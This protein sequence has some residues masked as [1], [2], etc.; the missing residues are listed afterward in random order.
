M[1]ELP[2]GYDAILS[3]L[4]DQIRTARL[5]A[6]LAVN[7]ELVLL[8]WRIG[9]QILKRQQEEGLGS[10]VIERLA[11]D[12]RKEFPEMKG[13]SPHNLKYMR[14]FA[15]AY[16]EELIVQQAAAQIPWFHNCVILYKVKNSVARDFYIRSTI[17]HGWSRNVLVH[18]IESGL[19]SGRAS[20][21]HQGRGSWKGDPRLSAL[22]RSI[23]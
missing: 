21:G 13:L 9:R 15:E 7:R 10:K 20:A 6:G 17:S 8:Y 4:K 3:G 22:V 5:K 1:V 2:I 18:Q 14:A 11:Q 19:T 12:L 16:P 23:F